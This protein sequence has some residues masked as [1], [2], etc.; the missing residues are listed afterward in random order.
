MLIAKSLYKG[1]Y[2]KQIHVN[3][4]QIITISESSID[5][6]KCEYDDVIKQY[7]LEPIHHQDLFFII[8]DSTFINNTLFLLTSCGI[9]SMKYTNSKWEIINREILNIDKEARNKLMYISGN[10]KYNVICVYSNTNLFFVFFINGNKLTLI[11]DKKFFCDY[12][13]NK[14]SI[15][16]ISDTVFCIEVLTQKG[17]KVKYNNL[18]FSSGNYCII[19]LKDYSTNN[20]I[21]NNEQKFKDIEKYIEENN[22]EEQVT[23]IVESPKKGY[24][25]IICEKGIKI[26]KSSNHEI[27]FLS[28]MIYHNKQSVFIMSLIKDNFIYLIFDKKCLIYEEQSNNIL[29]KYKFA[30]KEIKH[31]LYNSN[32]LSMNDGSFLFYNIK[33]NMYFVKF[34]FDNGTVTPQL[35]TKEENDAM[36][37]FDSTLFSHKDSTNEVSSCELY[38]VCGLKG[39]SRIVKY[40]EGYKEEYIKQIP[41]NNNITNI[42]FTD[43]FFVTTTSSSSSLYSLSNDLNAKYIKDYPLRAINIYQI[44]ANQ[45]ALILSKQIVLLNIENDISD[46]VVLNEENADILIAY[47]L[48]ANNTPLVFYYLNTGEIKVFDISSSSFVVLQIP[49]GSTVSSM[50]AVIGLNNIVSLICGTYQNSIVVCDYDTVNKVFIKDWITSKSY[51]LSVDEESQVPEDIKTKNQYVFVTSRTGKLIQFVYNP[52][53]ANDPLYPASCVIISKEGYPLS[54]SNIENE[55]NIYTLDIYGGNKAYSFRIDLKREIW[56]KLSYVFIDKTQDLLSFNTLGKLIHIYHNRN[57]LIFS[58]FAKTIKGNEK[59]NLVV[60]T[61]YKFNSDEI[62]RKIIEINNEGLIAITNQ[63]SIYYFKTNNG[64]SLINKYYIDVVSIK[65]CF[66]INSIKMYT[67]DFPDEKKSNYYLGICAEYIYQGSYKGAFFL[68]EIDTMSNSLIQK[69]RIVSFPKPIYDSCMISD[70]LIFGM[71]YYICMFP[72]II[73]NTSLALKK[74]AKQQQFLNKIISLT[75]VGPVNSSNLILI[76]DN[77]ESFCL[78][79]FEPKTNRFDVLGAELSKRSLS[80]IFSLKNN[81]VIM[82]EKNG[83]F[84]IFELRDEVYEKINSIDLKEFINNVNIVNSNEEDIIIMSGLMGSMYIGRLLTEK[85]CEEMGV[86]LEKVKSMM[87]DIMKKIYRK[88]MKEFFNR[89]IE[90]EDSMMMVTPIEQTV[91]VDFVLNMWITYEKEIKE[92]ITEEELTMVK[93]LNDQLIME[94]E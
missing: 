39:E 87:K 11:N 49:I 54:I 24:Y 72:L 26:L 10:E 59:C 46:S 7:V 22:K 73:T 42:F 78:G 17:K 30:D 13:I 2:T 82:T 33:A 74:E 16:E 14:V 94:I 18:Y 50:N 52:N 20:E 51:N 41:I 31:L 4:N 80:Q 57:N 36:F 40:I 84:S 23:D 64:F 34:N 48:N 83:T 76:G 77:K 56:R 25:F 29:A 61:M 35:I 53:S 91:L 65:D 15:K 68:Y 92:I 47:A 86:T 43:N 79:Q 5:L 8:F 89:E 71:E 3:N 1:T 67:L 66:K 37:S 85:K 9:L 75:N 63:N 44:A 93:M 60:E 28:H 88:M 69:E 90:G 55:D 81:R 21:M 6:A 58:Y 38:G 19:E 12:Y 45:Y 27:S 70:Y 62:C 32:I